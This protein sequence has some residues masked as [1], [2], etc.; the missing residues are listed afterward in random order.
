M[1]EIEGASASAAAA[2]ADIHRQAFQPS[3]SAD[4]IATLID[5]L[6]AVALAARLDGRLAGFI[7]YRIAADEAEV[8]TIATVPE[9]RGRGVAA[10]LLERAMTVTM[11]T[12]VTSVFLEVAVDNAAALGLYCSRG[13]RAVGERPRYYARPDGDVAALIMRADLNR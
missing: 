12:Q 10:A 3:W 6:G 9:L 5:G 4:E 2:L 7:I 8:L 13:F 11:A 1:I